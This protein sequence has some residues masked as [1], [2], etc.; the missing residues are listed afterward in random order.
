MFLNGNGSVTDRHIALCPVRHMPRT[1]PLLVLAGL[2]GIVADDGLTILVAVGMFA[3]PQFLS[4]HSLLV[5]RIKIEAFF[6]RH[7]TNS[8]HLFSSILLP[9][10]LSDMF[11]DGVE[12]HARA[13]QVAGY[14]IATSI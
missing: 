10:A 8:H 3:L 2:A 12:V 6:D 5:K 7:S 14:W 13:T 4:L 9:M 1:F 11:L